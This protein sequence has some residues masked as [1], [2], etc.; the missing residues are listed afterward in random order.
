[1]YMYRER[2]MYVCMHACMYV[3]MYVVVYVFIVNIYIYIYIYIHVYS[4]SRLL[5]VHAHKQ[6]KAVRKKQH[7]S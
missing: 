2:E 7:Y 6:E 1:M 3:C 5:R 4:S